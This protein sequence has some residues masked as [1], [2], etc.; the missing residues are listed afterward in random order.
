MGSK[1]RAKGEREPTGRT[2]SAII[3]FLAD[4]GE[5][6][7]T[8]IRDHL[9][10]RYNIKSG[11]DVKLHLNDLSSDD[12]LA[13]IE[14]ASH[15]NG[16]ANTYRIREGFNCLKRLHNFLNRY[17]MV[18]QLMKTGYFI[19]YTSSKAFDTRM[20]TNIVR[21]S[22]LELYEAIRDDDGY[23]KI[24]SML[25]VTGE[26]REKLM[27]WVDRVRAGDREDTL[28]GSFLAIT[29]MLKEGD[30]DHLGEIFTGI[31]GLL[32]SQDFFALMENLIIPASKREMVTAIRRLSPGALD[33]LLNSSRNNPLFPPN[34]FLAYAFSLIL[35]SPGENF[36]T[37]RLPAIDFAP[38]RRYSMALPRISAEPPIV[39]IARSLFVS[40]MVQGR[41]VGEPPEDKL[42]LIL[43][44]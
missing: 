26:D 32:D 35:E 1:T 22:M 36:L 21:N 10:E 43:S 4:N 24:M 27:E 31:I 8:E 14:K 38:Y 2:K 37:G 20:R 25:L 40:D 33:Y 3:L 28:S 44:S 18:P 9:R 13:V 12:R 42:R 16:N 39:L 5:C 19:D 6:K 17:G 15:G 30:I 41:L 11:K 23:E 29:D 34:V 7:A